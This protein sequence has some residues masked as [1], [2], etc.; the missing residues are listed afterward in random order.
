[1][2]LTDEELLRRALAGEIIGGG[3]KQVSLL[4]AEVKA[5]REEL[6][7][8][9]AKHPE[10]SCYDAL[11]KL[12][13]KLTELRCPDV[14]VALQIIAKLP[15]TKDGVPVVNGDTVYSTEADWSI[16]SGQLSWLSVNGRIEFGIWGGYRN[17]LGAWMGRW[18]IA[19]ECYSTREVAEAAARERA[20]RKAAEAANL[21]PGRMRRD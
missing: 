2:P 16:N 11:P 21:P 17:R 13:A 3:Q 4:V 10:D 20:E 9:R 1:M 5:Q 15:K 7:T 8:M 14:H 6:E 12:R 18:H 19:A